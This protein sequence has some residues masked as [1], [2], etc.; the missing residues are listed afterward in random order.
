MTRIADAVPGAVALLTS[1][2]GLTH[3]PEAALIDQLQRHIALNPNVGAVLVVGVAGEQLRNLPQDVTRTG[4]LVAAI[5][6]AEHLDSAA[7]V[8]HGTGLGREFAAKL[9]A[10]P[11]VQL[12]LSALRVGL[13]SSS[14]SLE[15]AR[16]VNQ[17]SVPQWMRW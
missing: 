10:H 13:R 1:A 16:L 9:A 5:G 11:R 15:S 4:R 17:Q 3:G 2:G 14:S 8:A 12:P 6:I 7:A